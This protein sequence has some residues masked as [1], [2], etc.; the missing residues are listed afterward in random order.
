MGGS[1]SEDPYLVSIGGE[2]IGPVEACCPRKVGWWRGEAGVG[3]WVEEH[4][5][6]GKG[7][8]CMGRWVCGEET[9]KG[10]NIY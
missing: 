7:E 6:R 2:V 5:L 3:W 4:P 1:M 9:E 8:G 10:D